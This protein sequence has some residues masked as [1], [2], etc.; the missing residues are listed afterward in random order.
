MYIGL[1]V[2][3]AERVPRRRALA[4]R[5]VGGRTGAARFVVLDASSRSASVHVVAIVSPNGSSGLLRV[6]V[7]A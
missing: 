4:K 6:G 5:P 7:M 3:V 1:A 2:P